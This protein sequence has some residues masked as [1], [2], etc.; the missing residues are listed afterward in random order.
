MT[1]HDE[2]S[3]IFALDPEQ[4]NVPP[5]MTH[6]HAS[7][8][9]ALISP[10]PLDVLLPKTWKTVDTLV[11]FT[12]RVLGSLSDSGEQYAMLVQQIVTRE[13]GYLGL[14]IICYRRLWGAAGLE[15]DV[16]ERL[17]VVARER[18]RGITPRLAEGIRLLL[19][20]RACLLSVMA[21]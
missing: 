10:T 18:L 3:A 11:A 4:S 16:R 2:V 13:L 6:L 21:S 8:Q 19:V 7:L 20:S 17:L 9:E 14:E 12:S 1:S 5:S 15:W